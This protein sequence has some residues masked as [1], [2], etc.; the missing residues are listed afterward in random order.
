MDYA[1]QNTRF[2]DVNGDGIVDAVT[3]VP[4]CWEYTNEIEPGVVVDDGVTVY[5]HA[6]GDTYS[7]V[8]LGDGRGHFHSSG[9]RSGFAFPAHSADTGTGSVTAGHL[10]ED[11]L[12]AASVLYYSGGSRATD[13]DGDGLLD[14]IT[15]FG[16]P[17]TAEFYGQNIVQWQT[18]SVAN[19]DGDPYPEVIDR[20]EDVLDRLESLNAYADEGLESHLTTPRASIPSWSIGNSV[21]VRPNFQYR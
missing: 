12:I 1:A 15:N 11:Y 2:A 7:R 16:T 21:R 18:W 19:F 14:E 17:V 13:S 3:A 8:F 5:L 10:I 6:T 9:Q 4:T 20:P